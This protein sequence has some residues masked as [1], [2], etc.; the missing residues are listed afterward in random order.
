MNHATTAQPTPSGMM[1]AAEGAELRR[2]IADLTKR[3]EEALRELAAMKASKIDWRWGITTAIALVLL[4][5]S[6]MDSGFD[7]V[8]K[9]IKSLETRLGSIESLLMGVETPQPAVYHPT[10]Y[11]AVP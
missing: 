8:N 6:V 2:Q 3:L 11:P 4:V 9:G 10:H 1:S 5:L 7:Q